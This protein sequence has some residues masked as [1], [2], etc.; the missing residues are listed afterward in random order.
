MAWP[1]CLGNFQKAFVLFMFLTTFLKK[2]RLVDE[3]RVPRSGRE[4][5]QWEILEIRRESEWEIL[6]GRQKKT[7]QKL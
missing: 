4:K 6:E 1:F 5:C 2:I 7:S 3:G